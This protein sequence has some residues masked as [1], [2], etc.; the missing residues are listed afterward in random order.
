[1]NCFKPWGLM[2]LLI[3]SLWQVNHSHSQ[4]FYYTGSSG[5]D[6]FTESNWNSLPGGGGTSP[7]AGS[8]EPGAG[9]ALQLII[10][11]DT[12]DANGGVE[13]EHGVDIA[14][15]GRLEIRS[16][17]T[18]NI[19]NDN[20]DAQFEI[21]S[22]ASFSM[23]DAMVTVQDDIFLRGESVFSG[24]AIETFFDDIEFLSSDLTINGTTFRAT[25][26]SSGASS[27]IIARAQLTPEAGAFINGATFFT[28][29]RFGIREFDVVA[30][31]S[32]FTIAVDLEDAFTNDQDTATAGLTLLGTSSLEAEQV[33]EGVKLILDDF[34]VATLNNVTGTQVTTHAWLTESSTV[35]INSP[36][37]QLIL[38]NTQILSSASK[39][40]NG[41]TGLAYEADPSTWN[42]TNWNGISPVTLQIVGGLLEPDADFDGDGDVDGRDFLTW[43]RNFGA[44]GQTNNSL[45]D[46]NGDGTVNSLDLAEWQTQYGQPPLS[47]VTSI[48]EPATCVL[49]IFGA[50][51]LY[52]YRRKPVRA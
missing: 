21:S 18:L 7:V 46:A 9:I 22:G 1:M 36:D 6:F 50:S 37:A 33:Q 10:D 41:I 20:F 8:I 30:T 40:I 23:T 29:S 47:H 45:G 38:E 35:T 32:I 2:T 15:G 26:V 44:I 34:A 12:V 52:W 24:G 16:G 5:G 48:P 13:S 19:Y 25:D 11:G 49:L 17:S 4:T 31:D 27:N 3:F 51:C 14:A 28:N 43:Q 39:V 42:V